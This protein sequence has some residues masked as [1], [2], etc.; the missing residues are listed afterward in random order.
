MVAFQSGRR[1]CTGH[2]KSD[3]ISGSGVSARR[4]RIRGHVVSPGRQAAEGRVCRSRFNGPFLGRNFCG[5]IW[6]TCNFMNMA[7]WRYHLGSTYTCIC[8]WREIQLCQG[9]E[10]NNA[11]LCCI[12][13]PLLKCKNFVQHCRIV[14]LSVDNFDGILCANRRIKFARKLFGRNVELH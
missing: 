5:G 1:A 3:I 14:C 13:V 10:K 11:A 2:R 6:I 7:R 8:L 9:E 4:R 12:S